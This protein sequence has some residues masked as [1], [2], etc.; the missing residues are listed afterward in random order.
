MVAGVDT[1]RGD[2]LLEVQ[3]DSRFAKFVQSLEM[4]VILCCDVASACY[5]KCCFQV[6]DI[7]EEVGIFVCFVFVLFVYVCK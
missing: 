6:G 1:E 3:L 2:I 7:C 5:L 4:C